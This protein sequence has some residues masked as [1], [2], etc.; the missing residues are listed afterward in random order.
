MRTNRPG[1]IAGL[2]VA[3]LAAGCNRG[4]DTDPP[5]IAYGQTECEHCKMIVS[6]EPFAAALVIV[7]A[8]G[9]VT[10]YAFDDVGC[11]LDY[12]EDRPVSG[13][14]IAYVHDFES[15]AW[16]DADAAVFVRSEALQTP[17]ASNLAASATLEGAQR[18][19]ARYPGGIVRFAELRHAAA[20]AADHATANGRNHP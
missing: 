3:G 6:D 9:H 8:D 16:L 19:L 1:L 13:R 10:K 18:L 15:K 11:V 12:L 17:M 2:A 4:G 7:A 14:A 5:K 20:P